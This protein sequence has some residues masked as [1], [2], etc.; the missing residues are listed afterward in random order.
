[1]GQELQKD[2]EQMI[3]EIKANN[4]KYGER[5]ADLEKREAALFAA[6]NRMDFGANDAP[7]AKGPEAKAMEAWARTGDLESK[8]LSISVDGQ[9]VS[10]RADWSDRVFALIRE[11]SPVRRVANVM[12][13]TKNEIEVLVDRGEPGSAWVAETA[14]RAE[15]LGSFMSR[16]KIPVF[17]HY[18]YP[19]V[20]THLLADSAFDVELWLQGKIGVRFSEQEN[21]AFINGDGIGKPKG[22]LNYSRVA[23]ASHTWGADPSAYTIGE[24]RT[25]TAGTLGATPLDRISDLVDALKAPYLPGAS[26]LMNR[27]MRNQVRK[28]K[29]ADGRFLFQGSLS[30]AIPDTLMG[31]P[32]YLSE[33][34]PAPAAGVV[35]MLFGDFRQAYTVVDRQGIE[36]TRDPFTQPG[37]IRYYVTKRTGGALTNP[38]A[39][40]AL[41]LAA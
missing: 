33:N 30:A 3:G 36:V 32:V 17:E 2:V 20:T 40:K 19:S 15:T 29:D 31:Y 13:T 21:E 12:T 5:L 4:A 1:M 27:A 26:F 38:E 41:T 9:G 10:V 24:I 22:M 18:A 35:G 8:A 6:Q 23:N 34:M 37:N 7:R 11:T 14:T 16:H 28:L 25:G 39:V